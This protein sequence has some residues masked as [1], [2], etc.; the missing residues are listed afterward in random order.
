MF[1]PTVT[2][3]GSTL[4]FAFGCFSQEYNGVRV[5]WSYGYWTAISALLIHVPEIGL[6]FAVL[7]NADRLSADY[8]LGAGNLLDSPVAQ[9]FLNAFVFH[10][11]VALP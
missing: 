5:I 1:T 3:S 10:R 6:T 7:A 2:S 8:A 11:T 9:E 4:P